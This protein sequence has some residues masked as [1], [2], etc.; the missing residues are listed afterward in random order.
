[1]TTLNSPETT[2][3]NPYSIN[4]VLISG[5]KIVPCGWFT[6]II[7]PSNTIIYIIII[8]IIYNHG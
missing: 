2:P 8:T 7:L 5:F 4:G 1:M 6:Q 3:T